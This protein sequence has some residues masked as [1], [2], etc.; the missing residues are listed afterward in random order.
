MK[1]YSLSAVVVLIACGF[2]S[3]AG[4]SYEPPQV[5]ST[6]GAGGAN[7]STS[8]GQGGSSGQGVGGQSG[9]G[10]QGIE[11]MPDMK[12]MCGGDYGGPPGTEGVGTCKAPAAPCLNDG[13]WGA[14]GKAVLPVPE[15]CQGTKD[16]NCDKLVPC[17]GAPIVPFSVPAAQTARDEIILAMAAPRG[18]AGLSDV[19]YAVGTRDAVLNPTPSTD[20]RV[21]FWV[22]DG[23][24]QVQDW[25]NKFVF[26]PT[27]PGTLNGAA[28][29]GVAVI[30]TTGEVIVTGIFFGGTLAI[31][32]DPVLINATDTTTFIAKLSPTGTVLKTS[33]STGNGSLETNSLATDAAG[34]I[35]IGGT[36]SG[37]PQIAQVPLPASMGP[38]GFVVCIAKDWNY[39]WHKVFAATGT[40]TVS[41]IAAIGD[42]DIVVAT[43]FSGKISVLSVGGVPTFDA[44]ATPDILVSR[45][46][47]VSGVAAWNT[48]IKSS[49]A[50]ANIE[51]GGLAAN[52][53]TIA[54][55]GRFV[56]SVELVGDPYTNNETMGTLDSFV[57]KL[58]TSD[59]TITKQLPIQ[60]IGTQ[61][62]RAM[63]FDSFGDV[64]VAGTYSGTLP[65]PALGLGMANGVDAFVTKLDADLN[66]R[67]GKNFGNDLY[68]GSHAVVVGKSTGH[69]FAGGGFQGDLV[70][71]LPLLT[72]AGELDAFI[73]ELA[74]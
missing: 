47:G 46:N 20:L 1:S 14:C 4:C 31:E 55:G 15:G 58:S 22:R 49:G 36:Y 68:Q 66:V 38:D 54:I 63:A 26:T 8:S 12:P 19:V 41:A 30:P 35:F 34:N 56:K 16:I 51:V 74:N 64:V 60:E 24:G 43:N 42:T 48:Q 57:A 27:T 17:T 3:S 45:L 71:L 72:S 11:C 10:G 7:S 5:T 53:T 39:R 59:G 69:V 73:I 70:G 52:A 65:L 62:V 61:E 44:N 37:T 2:V 9:A 67:W 29:T 50:S 28:A 6:N 40:Q 32:G 21:L 25:S 13:M 33:F 23:N 18:K